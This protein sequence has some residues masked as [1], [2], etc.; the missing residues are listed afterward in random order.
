[1][2]HIET[3][4]RFKQALPDAEVHRERVL[5]LRRDNKKENPVQWEDNYKEWD[6]ESS[7][8]SPNYPKETPIVFRADYVQDKWQWV[9]LGE[10]IL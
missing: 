10:V 5:R 4:L 1:M 7:Y 6:T 3:L 2:I 9:F 8:R